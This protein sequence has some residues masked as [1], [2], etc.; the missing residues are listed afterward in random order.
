MKLLF[1]LPLA[2]GWYKYFAGGF[3]AWLLVVLVLAT[4]VLLTLMYRDWKKAAAA[5]NVVAAAATYQS[6]SDPSRTQVHEH[7]IEIIKRSGWRGSRGPTFDDDVQRFGWYALSMAEL[8]V[9]PIC[10][11][12]GW[13]PVRNPF[14]AVYVELNR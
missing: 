1:L 2:Y 8:G 9:V 7:A 6:L 4:V 13:N 12:K 14:V 5:N 11:I 10:V 3:S